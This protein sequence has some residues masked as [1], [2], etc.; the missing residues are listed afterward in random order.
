MRD[1]SAFSIMSANENYYSTGVLRSEEVGR[2]KVSRARDGA[3]LP[4]GKNLGR[5][6]RVVGSW[7]HG[8]F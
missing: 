5:W 8:E 6:F 2:F 7:N 1:T 4:L 3:V